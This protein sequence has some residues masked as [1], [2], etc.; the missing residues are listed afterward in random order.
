[1][2]K[3]I[4]LFIIIVGLFICWFGVKIVLAFPGGGGGGDAPDSSGS[5]CQKLNSGAYPPALA[6]V[7]KD[8]CVENKECNAC[9]VKYCVEKTANN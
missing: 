2:K 3:T 6:A 1:M 9:S 7:M 8:C 4:L 5:V